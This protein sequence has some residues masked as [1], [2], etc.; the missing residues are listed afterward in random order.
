M[1]KVLGTTLVLLFMLLIVGL[2]IFKL[3]HDKKNG[4]SCCGGCGGDC[5]KCKGCHH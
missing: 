1:N 3:I 4:K 5:S 2:S